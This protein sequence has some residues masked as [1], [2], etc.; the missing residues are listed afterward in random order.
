MRALFATASFHVIAGSELVVQEL[1]EELIFRGWSCDL[2]A[3]NI[4]Q[5]M[6]SIA[7]KS[8]INI[9]RKPVDIN[10]F[11]YDLVWIQNRLEPVFSY[12]ANEASCYRT[13]FIFAHLDNNWPYAK[14]GFYFERQLGELF[15]TP[16]EEGAQLL[17][18]SGIS[19]EKIVCFRNAAPRS[20]AECIDKQSS[21]A[22]NLLIVSN[23]L[24]PELQEA[25]QILESLYLNV[26]WFGRGGDIDGQR[27]TRNELAWADAVISIGKTVSYAI[28]SKKPIYIYGHFGGPGWL[29]ENNFS[30]AS[31]FNF[32]GRCCNRKLSAADIVEEIIHGYKSKLNISP[33]SD[34]KSFFLESF[35]DDLLMLQQRAST[36]VEHI[37]KLLSDPI[38]FE[39][40]KFYG[41]SVGHYFGAYLKL[42]A[43]VN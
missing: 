16:A 17:I 1:A 24:A 34:L 19:K 29:D 31:K 35:I 33:S 42:K 6:A 12:N 28:R 20:F 3:W 5:P 38:A 25:K 43:R 32:S 27:I 8:G 41:I 14:P 40:E 15:V 10:P 18:K 2:T 30:V 37:E 22:Q 4:G 39:S 7:K 11:D 13:L 36:S 21:K 26:R 9:L 23:H